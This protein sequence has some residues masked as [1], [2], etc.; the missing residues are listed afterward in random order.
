[1]GCQLWINICDT[2]MSRALCFGVTLTSGNNTLLSQQ[3]VLL[4]WWSSL[5]YKEKT[6]SDKGPRVMTT[7]MA[8]TE[9]CAYNHQLVDRHM[10]KESKPNSPLPTW[11]EDGLIQHPEKVRHKAGTAKLQS[12]S[13]MRASI[14]N[15]LYA[16]ISRIYSQ[17]ER[18]TSSMKEDGSHMY[19]VWATVKRQ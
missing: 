10:E 13:A 15:K 8:I 1:M 5:R 9:R 18:I 14:M 3:H 11:I 7:Q 6:V 19:V 12:G 17:A 4:M 16:T 2:K